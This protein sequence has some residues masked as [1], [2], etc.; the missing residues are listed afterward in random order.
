M[1]NHLR[2]TFRKG[3]KGAKYE[4]TPATTQLAIDAARLIK[5]E[6]AGIDLFFDSDAFKVCEVNS[7]P[8]FQTMEKYA[9][10]DVATEILTYI[11]RQM[12]E[13]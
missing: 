8:G 9:D 5:M 11:H 7:S 13:R 10:V 6:I 12:V 4:M 1:A 2:P 3:G